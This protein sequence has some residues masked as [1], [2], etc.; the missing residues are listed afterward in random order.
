MAETK[1]ILNVCMQN[2]LLLDKEVL[3][4]FKQELDLEI[5]SLIIKKIK[6]VFSQSVLTKGVF[7]QNKE[8]I[9]E[10]FSS[11]PKES[12]EQLERFKI[13][14]G[15]SIEF[16]K[17]VSIKKKSSNENIGNVKVLTSHVKPGRKHDVK[18]FVNFY[19]SRFQKMKGFL[20]SNAKLTDSLVSINKISGDKSSFSIIG[21]VS[22]KKV[23]QNK[24]LLLEVEDMTGSMRV[25]ISKDKKEL[26][27]E[28]SEIVL[29]SVL[30]FKGVGNGEILFA[31]DVV[32]PDVSLPE[33][34]NSPYEEYAL[35]ISDLHYGSKKFML[36]EFQKFLDYLN[37]KMP[38]TPEVEKIKYLF[39]VGDLITGIGNYPQQER[40][41]KTGSLEDQFVEIAELLKQVPNR[42]KVILSPGNHDC[43]RL[44]EPQPM[45]NEKYAWP[46]YD[47]ENMIFTEN[48]ALVNIGARDGFSGFNVLSY[49]G[50]SFFYYVNNVPSLLKMRAANCPEKIM[51]FLLKYRHLAPSHGSIQFSPEENDANV[52]DVIPD[53]FVAGHTHKSGV[54]YHNNVLVI[55]GSSWE[56]KTSYQEKFG[57]EPDHCKVIMF[58]LKT[59]AVKVLDF[60]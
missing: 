39:I 52:I 33:R 59:R 35:F 10:F 37:G 48:P 46:L 41:L 17:E 9:D 13:K 21:M 7:Y 16:T 58:N 24:N 2:G 56:G 3:N 45:I 6:S 22:D 31:N 14:L 11:F 30:G 25:L 29:D 26:Y 23:T 55:S 51:D 42:I 44:M 50:F 4:V 5:A 15:L 53:I 49:H 1:E 12:Q 54:T 18:E 60:E 43:V 47:V 20:E 28:A 34:K 27:E 57:N 19:R 36:K 38:N 8:K 40:D 32:F